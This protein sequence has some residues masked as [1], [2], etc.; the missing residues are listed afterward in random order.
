MSYDF[1]IKYNMQAVEG[2]LNAR[3]KEN[4]NLIKKL[5]RTWRHPLDTKFESYRV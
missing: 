2:K 4:K 5:D 1:S 3:I